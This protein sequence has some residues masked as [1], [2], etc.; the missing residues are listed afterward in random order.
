MPLL[1]SRHQGQR[2]HAASPSTGRKAC[3][4]HRALKR[5]GRRLADKA[6]H[7]IA[8]ISCSGGESAGQSDTKNLPV[9]EASGGR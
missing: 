5:Y 6:V 9:P 7:P 3:R 1:P 2:R 4:S 8:G